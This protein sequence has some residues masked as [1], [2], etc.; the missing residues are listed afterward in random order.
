MSINEYIPL[1][2]ERLRTLRP[3]K[4]ILFGSCA[5]GD[6]QPDS[7]IDVL[8]VTN[9]DDLPQN[10]QERNELYLNVSRA[11]RDIR[12]HVPIDL[13]VHTKPMHKKFIEL[14]SMFA[15]EILQKGKTLY[16]VDNERVA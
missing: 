4:I 3:H 2:I 8:V 7:D 9:S 10:Y 16:E 11:I 13:I 12:K 15:Q 1:M 5:Y 6:I 14:E